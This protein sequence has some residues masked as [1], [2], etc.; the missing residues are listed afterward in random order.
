MFHLFLRRHVAATSGLQPQ[1]HTQREVTNLH[2]VGDQHTTS[3]STRQAR[4]VS[5]CAHHSH[6]RVHAKRARMP[7]CRPRG[8]QEK[9]PR[10]RELGK[11]PTQ[12]LLAGGELLRHR[13]FRITLTPPRPQRL[14]PWVLTPN[15]CR[16][17]LSKVCFF[18]PHPSKFPS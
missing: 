15:A 17:V 4:H 18:F 2:R 7:S 5:P 14:E 9:A 16:L 1:T 8:R 12:C 13:S 6:A 3:R 10:A 11:L